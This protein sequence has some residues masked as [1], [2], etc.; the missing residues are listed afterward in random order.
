VKALVYQGPRDIRLEDVPKPG[1]R[2]PEDV[3]VRVTLSSIC[4]SDLH[5][6]HGEMPGME[7]GTVVGH[8]FTGVVE[9]VGA[10]VTEVVPG[11]RVLGPAAV[12]C[13]RCRACRRGLGMVCERRGILGC[14]SRFGNLAGAQAEFVRVPFANGTLEKIPPSLSDEQSIFAGD[15][16]PTAYSA[17]E[18]IAPGGRRIRTGDTVAVFGAGPVG[19]CAVACAKLFGPARVIAVDLEDDRLELASRLG[20][21]RTINA[22]REDP[23]AIIR[24]LTEGWGA[25]FLIEAAGS[26]RTLATSLSVVAPGGTVSAVGVSQKPVE[27]P[28]P[29][30]LNKNVSIQMGL[31]NLGHM[32]MLLGLIEAGRLDL[33]PLITHRLPLTEGVRAYE[34]FEQRLDGAVKV[35]LRP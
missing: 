24:E 8:E 34:I 12:W 35:M 23:K 33:T 27:I 20:A 9:E 31:G 17:A 2:D 32:G 11:D 13:G 19:L 30:L 25:D 29:R 3:V 15:I 16:L 1:V 14:G 26:P 10:A 28:F 7:P 6:L 18:G 5:V 22:S 4:G 21:D